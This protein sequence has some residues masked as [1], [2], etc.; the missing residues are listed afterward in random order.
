MN[1]CVNH[2]D[3]ETPYTCQKHGV[4]LCEECLAC[5]DPELYCK[6]RPSC[7]IWMIH[8]ERRREERR[9]AAKE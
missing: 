5:R 4:H 2:P 3:R 9:A 6:F 7:M 1:T 8:K